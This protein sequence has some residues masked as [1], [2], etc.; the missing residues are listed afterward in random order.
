MTIEEIR[1]NVPD[2]T[3]Y[4]EWWDGYH[5]FK[6]NKNGWEWWINNSWNNTDLLKIY[7][8]FGWKCKARYMGGSSHKLKP[9]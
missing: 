1:R 9:L 2:A 4:F 6:R 8:W 3:N 5:V 7:W